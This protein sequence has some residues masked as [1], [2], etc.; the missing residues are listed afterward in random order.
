MKK[1]QVAKEKWQEE[2]K[3]EYQEQVEKWRKA[4]S[5]TNSQK[6]RCITT[7]EI[8]PSQC[9]AARHYNI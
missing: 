4:G 3:K 9:E 8:F 2:H 7:N 6:I 1:I 5:E